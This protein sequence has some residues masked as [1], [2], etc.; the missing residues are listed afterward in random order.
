[1][2]QI[3]NSVSQLVVTDGK[4]YSGSTFNNVIPLGKQRVELPEG[5]VGE[6]RRH[7]YPYHAPMNVEQDN[8]KRSFSEATMKERK[9]KLG[10][11]QFNGFVIFEWTI[12][13][14]TFPLA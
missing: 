2:R 8:M 13:V 7:S 12:A 4:G 14:I 9:I 10:N 1:M 6:G 5:Y 3:D 11:G